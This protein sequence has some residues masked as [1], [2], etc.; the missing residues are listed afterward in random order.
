M[1]IRRYKCVRFKKVRTDPLV[2][3]FSLKSKFVIGNFNKNHFVG[4]PMCSV[5][6]CRKSVLKKTQI[7]RPLFEPCSSCVDVDLSF[8][9]SI[10]DN[11]WKTKTQ[12]KD[13]FELIVDYFCPIVPMSIC[14]SPSAPR[15]S[16]TY[17]HT[18]RQFFTQGRVC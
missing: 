16:F 5:L 10:K 1:D 11:F 15:Q 7:F 3:R 18:A 2:M 17:C 9:C 13:H 4:K 8:V 12:E 6:Q 14:F